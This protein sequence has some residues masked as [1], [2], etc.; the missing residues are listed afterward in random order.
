MRDAVGSELQLCRR[1][2]ARRGAGAGECFGG[3][4]QSGRDRIPFD[5]SLYAGALF[6]ITDQ[7]IVTFVEP[8]GGSVQPQHP[9][10]L[11][12]R[13]ALKGTEPISHFYVRRDEY[14][15]VVR[16][17]HKR[18]K[19][20]SIET[21]LAIED[22]RDHNLREFRLPQVTGAIFGSI[23][24]AIHCNKC[25]TRGHSYRREYS[26]GRQTT[27]QTERHEHPFADYIPVRQS[28]LVNPHGKNSGLAADFSQ[29]RPRRAEARRQ[30]GSPA[31]Q[32]QRSS[33]GRG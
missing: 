5:I 12:T 15:N 8:E 16:H 25:F 28:S 10:G 30:G 13:E 29:V 3:V 9:G 1:A 26:V 24:Q 19:F 20:V 23:Q 6:V 31:P 22:A 2:S 14:V 18:V 17:D 7:M 33:Y 11:P 4:A 21:P 32:L 27:V